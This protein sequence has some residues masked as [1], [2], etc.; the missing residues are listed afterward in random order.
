MLRT[1]ERDFSKTLAARPD[2]RDER[3]APGDLLIQLFPEV[4]P[5][6]DC[7]EVHQQMFA[8]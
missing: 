1:T 2:H 8:V 5:S 6:P 7:V 3:D 4:D